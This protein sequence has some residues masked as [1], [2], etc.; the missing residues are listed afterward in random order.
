VPLFRNVM[1]TLSIGFEW[2]DTNPGQGRENAPASSYPTQWRRDPCTTVVSR[3]TY[4][5]DL[6]RPAMRRI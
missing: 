4:N 5:P 6:L 1:A 3:Y 2:H